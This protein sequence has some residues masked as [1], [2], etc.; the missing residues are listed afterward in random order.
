LL[1]RGVIFDFNGTLFWDT[2]YHNE[3]WD[4][5]LGRN[6]M[7]MTDEEKDLRIHGKNNKDIFEGLYGRKIDQ[8]TARRLTGEKE[9]IYRDICLQKG[10]ELAPGAEDF[11]NFISGEGIRMNIATASRIENVRFFFK[12]QKLERW[13]DPE[14][15]VFDDG[16]IPGKPAPDY[17]LMAAANIGLDISEC[18]VFE[19]SAA[20]ITSA[21]AAGAGKIFQVRTLK[22]P[23]LDFKVIT[24]R[25]YLGLMDKTLF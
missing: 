22:N 21:H 19:D 20:G 6:G 8:E 2:A 9:S 17:Y 16:H 1:L 14:K 18:I 15:V 10:M 7:K 12:E 5:W 4:I 11:L 13:F 3:A 24:V 25:D 23:A